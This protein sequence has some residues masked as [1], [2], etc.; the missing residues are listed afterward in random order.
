MNEVANLP[1]NLTLVILPS[2][3]ALV[4]RAYEA[5]A[6]GERVFA[7]TATEDVCANIAVEADVAVT[8]EANEFARKAT[9]DVSEIVD[10]ATVIEPVM[11]FTT[12]DP[13]KNIKF[14]SISAMVSFLPKPSLKVIAI[15]YSYYIYKYC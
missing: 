5:V 1:T 13:L 14:S 9:D 2:R 15:F 6:N 10:E 4:K 7:I 12:Y 3:T 11:L 8:V